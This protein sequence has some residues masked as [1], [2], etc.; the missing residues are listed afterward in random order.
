MINSALA[1]KADQESFSTVDILEID[2]VTG[3]SEF[4]KIGSAQSFIKRKKEIG[5]IS[6]KS[7]PVGILENI[8]AEPVR[9]KLETG[10]IIVMVSDGVS[11]AGSGVLKSDWIKKLLLLEKRKPWEVAD[12]IIEGAKARSKF[13]DDMTCCVIKIEK[14]K[15]G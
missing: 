12:L 1:L 13:S 7:L 15:E 6:S 11:E 14:R 10:D 5:V 4:L 9:C 2:M 8:E 3:E